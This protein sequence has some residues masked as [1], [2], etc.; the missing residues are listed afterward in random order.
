MKQASFNI[1][2]IIEAGKINSELE[3]EQSLAAYH[4][5]RLLFKEN[6]S[7]KQKRKILG[8]LIH[9]YEHSNWALKSKTSKE[10][11]IESEEAGQ[12]VV[13]ENAFIE[14]R[15]QLIKRKLAK[16]NLNQQE[17]G[18]IL[19]HNS[20]SYMSELMN[21]VKPF[22]LKDLII[23]S[24]LLKINLNNLI[25]RNVSVNERKDIEQTIKKLNKPNLKL[26]TEAFALS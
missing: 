1:D 4:K 23:I 25:F 2:K 26:D 9:K 19:G 20:K 15:K 14:K 17:F 21:G 5:L 10:Q 3:L 12:L 6:P 16:H 24:K 18:E 8:E 7:L 11:I 22:S 13:Q